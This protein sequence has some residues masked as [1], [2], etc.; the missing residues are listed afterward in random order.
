MSTDQRQL[1]N[2]ASYLR[3]ILKAD[4]LEDA[5]REARLALKLTERKTK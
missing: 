4:T 2:I 5:Q 1:D 3:A